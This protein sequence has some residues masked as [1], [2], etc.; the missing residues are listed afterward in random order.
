MPISCDTDTMSIDQEVITID[1]EVDGWYESFENI[2]NQENEFMKAASNGDLRLMNRMVV[3][4]DFSSLNCQ[5]L[6]GLT[7]LH[8]AAIWG[9]FEVVEYLLRKGASVDSKDKKNTTPLHLAAAHGRLET[10]I[11]LL[12]KGAEKDAQTQLKLTPLHFAGKP[13]TTCYRFKFILVIL[14][15]KMYFD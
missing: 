6:N 4:Q 5:D 10:I 2:A 13:T 14:L 9:I 7:P 12:G 1:A 3:E 8:H 11:L 15:K